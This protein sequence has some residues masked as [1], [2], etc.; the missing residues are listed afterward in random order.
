[1][2]VGSTRIASIGVSHPVALV[3]RHQHEQ[4]G[5]DAHQRV[6]PKSRGA[7]VKRALEADRRADDERAEDAHRD[8]RF[9]LAHGEIHAGTLVAAPSSRNPTKGDDALKPW[10]CK[11]VDAN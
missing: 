9:L 1:M 7:A 3:D 5:G 8:D 4:R 10:T 6:R 2:R 11:P